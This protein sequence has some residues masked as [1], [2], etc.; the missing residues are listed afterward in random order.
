MWAAERQND[1]IAQRLWEE[2]S[3]HLSLD[4]DEITTER[5]IRTKLDDITTP[6]TAEAEYEYIVLYGR[7]Y[8]RESAGRFITLASAEN[9]DNGIDLISR[10]N[11]RAVETGPYLLCRRL[12]DTQEAAPRPTNPL[13]E[14]LA[15]YRAGPGVLLV[16]AHLPTT[17]PDPGKP[18][19]HQRADVVGYSGWAT[20][21]GVF[22]GD[23][24]EMAKESALAQPGRCTV[25]EL[26]EACTCYEGVVEAHDELVKTPSSVQL[27]GD[28]HPVN[29]GG[30]A[31][32]RP[33]S[34]ASSPSAAAR[35]TAGEPRPATETS[36][37]GAGRPPLADGLCM[38]RAMSRGIEVFKA[39]PFGFIGF[40]AFLLLTQVVLLLITTG[41]V[42]STPGGEGGGPFFWLSTMFVTGP[43]IAGFYHVVFEILRGRQPRFRDFFKGFRYTVSMAGFVFVGWVLLLMGITVLVD[44]GKAIW[45][46]LPIYAS[47]SMM[48]A[49]PLIVDKRMDF[50]R[51]IVNSWRITHS[52]FVEST[53]LAMLVSLAAL[54]GVALFGV[55]LLASIPLAGCILTVAYSNA[56]GLA[57]N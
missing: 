30:P 5:L 15:S 37:P 39:Y 43:L 33:R 12:F 35:S 47:F 42:S 29:L 11:N 50:L 41:L 16:L 6:L 8:G 28:H 13:A 36:A 45:L 56:A 38:D 52:R 10:D 21:V 26:A 57:P 53:F 46:V 31:E 32:S 18:I 34:A 55:G 14:S 20:V 2:E 23:G 19:A 51:A 3:R 7:D 27:T 25:A 24:L 48:F 44:V 4:A 49:V 22:G 40:T 1:S 54:C 9:Q 17:P